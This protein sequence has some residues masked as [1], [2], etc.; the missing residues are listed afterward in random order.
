MAQQKFACLI[1]ALMT[2]A[3]PALAQTAGVGV[4]T[5]L[6]SSDAHQRTGGTTATDSRSIT[7]GSAA[8]SRDL[9]RGV[10]SDGS[11]GQTG[12]VGTSLNGRPIGFPGSGLGSREDSLGIITR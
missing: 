4:S 8:H 5:G 1:I 2:V 11:I 12:K 7:T 10:N 6:A 9:Q 3:P